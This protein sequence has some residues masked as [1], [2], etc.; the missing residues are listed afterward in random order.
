MNEFDHELIEQYLRHQLGEAAHRAVEAQMAADEAFR[1]EVLLHAQALAAINFQGLSELKKR[2]QQKEAVHTLQKQKKQR[3]LW[4]LAIA[5]LTIGVVL[6]YWFW[7]KTGTAAQNAQPIQKTPFDQQNREPQKTVSPDTLPEKQS[8]TSSTSPT[9]QR[10]P[11]ANPQ[12]L[13]ATALQAYQDASLNPNVRDD[14][15]L[16]PFEQFMQLYWEKKYGP[17]IEAFKQLD[18]ALQKN[19]DVLF[20]KANAL[21]ASGQT[22]AAKTLFQ[23]I[24]TRKASRFAPQAEWYLALAYLKNVDLVQVQKQLQLISS[25]PNH[26]HRNAALALLKQLGN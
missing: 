2:L 18:P 16:S 15:N 24:I 17:A 13:F 11:K 12:L 6:L 14:Q 25:Q 22:D 26:P 1:K 10:K 21:L 8:S 23:A 9:A 20:L 7:Y 19:D 4:G 3:L 5:V